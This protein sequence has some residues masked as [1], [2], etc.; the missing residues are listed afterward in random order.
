MIHRFFPLS[1]YLGGGSGWGF[2]FL[3]LGA[4]ALPL[5]AQQDLQTDVCIY[6]GT[7]AGVMAAVAVH[8]QGKSVILIEPG[9]HLGGMTSGGLGETDIGNKLVIGGLSREFYRRLGHELGK[10]EA[11]EFPPSLAEKVFEQFIAENHIGVRREYRI[12]RAE[13]TGIHLD[14]IVLEHVPTDDYNAPVEHGDGQL[15]TVSAK[16]F[17]D[18]SYEGD[19][20]AAAK[21]SYTVGRESTEQYGESLNGIR[22]NTPKHQ[23]LVHVDPFVRPGDGTSGLLPLIKEMD[24]GTP[25]SADQRVQ[26]YNFRVCLTDVA[27]NRKPFT[28]PPGYDAKQFELLARYIAALQ[29][30]GKPLSEKTFLDWHVMPGRKT[31]I[32][33]NGGFS[34]DFIGMSWEY[35]DGS[36]GRRGK[37]WHATRDYA[38]G[39]FYFLATDSRSP[40]SI[41]DYLSK[42]GLCADEFVDTGGWPHQMYVREARRMVGDYVVTQAVCLHEQTATDSVGMAAYNMDSHNCTRCVKDGAA[43]NEGDVQVHPHGPY[44]ISMRAIVPKVSEVDNLI[45][46][47]CLSASHIA[48]GSI[49]MEPVFMVLGQSAG[50]MACQAI[51]ENISVQKMDMAKLL[52]TLRAAGQVLE[53]PRKAGT[54]PK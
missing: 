32:N 12:V 54:K 41:R 46:P 39:L 33:N 44:P 40:Q 24:D 53:M 14:R 36:Y 43:M 45:V 22:A 2:F 31:D 18:A 8:Q 35:P 26:A 1:L 9:R 48:Y 51:D 5:A 19:L 38:Q 27:D 29:A 15:L 34:T 37:I 49:R 7:S 28:P 20:M 11:W 25:G 30:A 3:F 6:G 50:V 10:A 23:F 42:W 16:E 13:K 17:I 21:V 4:L 47:V 52:M